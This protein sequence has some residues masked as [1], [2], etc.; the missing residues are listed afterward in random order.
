MLKI[1]KLSSALGVFVFFFPVVAFAQIPPPVA[2]T[3][4]SFPAV[5][6]GTPVSNA[7]SV[8]GGVAPFTWSASDLPSGVAIDPSTGVVSGTPVLPTPWSLPLSSDYSFTA[9]VQDEVGQIAT[10]TVSWTVTPTFTYSRTPVG[11]SLSSDPV[12][13]QINGTFGVDVCGSVRSGQN[14]HY[15]VVAS[16]SSGN[17]FT[18]R[19]LSGS[20]G[21]P[22]NLTIAL[23]TGVY[24]DL[25]IRCDFGSYLEHFN[26]S[27]SVSAI[28]TITTD[29]LLQPGIVG[30]PYTA[31]LQYALNSSN[32]SLAAAPYSW[33]VTS[34][35]LP[36][37][38]SL[39]S[40]TGIISGTPT[41]V[42]SPATFTVQVQD[43]LGQT[44]SQVFTLSIAGS[45]NPPSI[46]TTSFPAVTM[47][48][49]V[50]NAISVSGGVAPF[51]W[52]ASDL[53]SGVA[54][55]PSTGVVSGTPVL[56]T[57]WSLPLSSDYSFTA[58]VQDEVGQIAT[59]TVSWTVTPTF[60][61]SRTPVGASLSSDPVTIQINGTF[62]VDV[63][64]SVRSGQNTHYSVV[65]SDS[66]GNQF[67]IRSLSGSVGQPVNLT[68]ALGTGVYDDLRIRCDFGSYL[69]HF[70]DSFSV[71][72]IPTI[73]TDPLLQPGIVGQ[74]YTATLQYALNSSNSS[75]AAAPYSWSVTSGALPAGLSLDSATGII[76][77]TPTAVASPATFT[78]QVQDALGQTAS[79]VFTLSIA[80]SANPPSITT[81]SFPAVTMGTPVSNAISVSGGVAPFTWSASDLPSGVAIDPS[82]GV[83]SGTPVLPTPWSLPLSSDYSFT[84]QVQDEVGQIATGTVSWTVTPTFTYSRTPVG[85][86]LSSDPVT[87]QINGTFGVDVCGSVRSGQNTHYSVVAS[88]SSGNQFTI[89]SLSGSVGQPV[90]LT[91]A[92]GTGVYDDL[93]IRCDFGSYLEH[94]ND[95][96]SVSA[97]PTI[98]TDPLLQP[99]IVGQP[100]T[101]TLQYALNSS[102]SSLAAAPYSWSVTSGA[103]PAGLSLDSST[104]TIS[105][106]PTVVATP[107]TFSVQVKDG[108]GQS[109][110][111]VTFTM[112]V[113]SP[114]TI[115]TSSLPP[116][117]VGTSYSQTLAASTTGQLP[118]TWSVVSGSLPPGLSL[119]PSS[120]SISGVSHTAGT[121][122]FTLQAMD[123]SGYTATKNFSIIV[124][125]AP[126]I[127]TAATLPEGT[128]TMSYSQF[129]SVSGGTAPLLWSITSGA[130]PTGLSLNASTGEIAGTPTANGTATFT[131]QVKD[132][133]NA[134]TSQTFRLRINKMIV[135]T[136]S[137]LT[138]GKVGS[139]YSKTFHATGGSAPFTWSV[140]SGTLPSGLSLTSNGTLS[141]VPASATSTEFTVQ[142]Q[143]TNGS[144]D[145][146]PIDLSI[147]P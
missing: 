32:S 127:T 102:N 39:D 28:P 56:P 141:G 119:N 46:T 36:A 20:V 112:Y 43:A 65:A 38:L 104:G 21:Q 67:T 10:G 88:D 68:I 93:R 11:A 59:G 120:G 5:T 30:Q 55:D 62:G 63:C 83:V 140:A 95:S 94:F 16:D 90:N 85:A 57:P 58:Q 129:I 6:M 81:T 107:V 111:P 79:Q 29:P 142:V 2:I 135:I 123:G 97:I 1:L 22:V 136:T 52:S 96:F 9:Q 98:T 66:S 13:I 78:V 26:D 106:T 12:T 14:T 125:P 100:Y 64:G 76:S 91:I 92:L 134:T 70:N 89:R 73:T 130:L 72:A 48:T 23:G 54:I 117:T 7:I 110:G 105:G 108:L 51:T 25:R 44:A 84:A 82:T 35:A 34:G 145:T 103:L 18:I 4:T 75:L 138:D 139:S 71:S 40:A 126:T 8:S 47:G 114:V 74:P 61:Y 137:N 3:T 147:K 77:G 15:S 113:F 144:I 27:F 49:P 45:A 87:I 143:D 33:S 31:T 115:T 122:S 50:S 101:A 69:E 60:T 99:G 121:Y 80:G 41:A 118:F 42:A 53:P 17:Q 131:V 146:H 109:S 86:S 128:L 133:N 37:G 132:A 24:D 124:N 116:T 19:S